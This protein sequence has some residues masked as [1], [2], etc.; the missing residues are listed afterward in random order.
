MQHPLLVSRLLHTNHDITRHLR[1]NSI[2]VGGLSGDKFRIYVLRSFFCLFACRIFQRWCH[3]S[4]DN[5][6]V[7]KLERWTRFFFA[8]VVIMLSGA[9]VFFG[10][11]LL[12]GAGGFSSASTTARPIQAYAALSISGVH[13]CGI[14][15]LRTPYLIK[16]FFSASNRVMAAPAVRCSRPIAGA[17]RVSLRRTRVADKHQRCRRANRKHGSEFFQ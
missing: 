10:R 15:S 1:T 6:D 2:F 16:V 13:C 11:P 3:S 17:L 12:R 5:P 4:S 9:N 8:S 14:C 7:S